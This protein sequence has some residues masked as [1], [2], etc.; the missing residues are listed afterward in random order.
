VSRRRRARQ[1]SGISQNGR[2]SIGAP[3][4]AVVSE[5]SPSSPNAATEEGLFTRFDAIG[6][7]DMR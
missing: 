2:T 6:S 1:A 4:A 5:F 7:R 3:T